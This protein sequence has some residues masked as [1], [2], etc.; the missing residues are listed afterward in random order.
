MPFSFGSVNEEARKFLK[1]E[2]RYCYT[3]PKSYL[4]LL[5]LYGHLLGD[6]RREAG[7]M[8]TR[9]TTGLTKLRDT[10]AEV[11]KIEESLKASATH[12]VGVWQRAG[13]GALDASDNRGV[14]ASGPCRGCTPRVFR[15]PTSAREF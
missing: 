3:T 11:A 6:K 13:M 1:N 10:A 12:G 5:A 7:A 9:L 4:E 8:I 15:A 14:A 2:R